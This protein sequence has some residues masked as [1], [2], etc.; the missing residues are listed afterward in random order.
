ML[1]GA[2]LTGCWRQGSARQFGDLLHQSVY[3][4]PILRE[5]RALLDSSQKRVSGDVRIRRHKGAAT[6]LGSLSP[7]SLLD[8][9]RRLGSTYGHGSSLW[10]GADARAFAHVYATAGRLAKLAED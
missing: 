5:T 9:S 4:D 8:A 2:T 1:G 10:T 3:Y 7:H 6:V